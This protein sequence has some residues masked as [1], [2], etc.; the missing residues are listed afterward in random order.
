MATTKW[1]IDPSHSEVQFKVKHLMVTTVTGHLTSFSGAVET[2]TE[3]FSD[4]KI[5]FTADLNSFTTGSEQRDQH[6]KGE[7]FFET[8]KFPELRF[9]STNF[10]KNA[11]GTYRLKGMLSIRGVSKEVELTTEFGGLIK[12]PWG[13][14]KAAFNLSGK[15]SRKEFGLV[16]NVVT[17]GGGVLVSD[18]V[19]LL[20]E[21]QL[22]EEALVEA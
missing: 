9:E 13:N 5:S 22:V 21:V 15:I 7:D 19:K 2:S 3:D 17:E 16:W 1:V 11:D 20:A 8:A 12:D 4:A 6:L 10:L 18:E 14:K